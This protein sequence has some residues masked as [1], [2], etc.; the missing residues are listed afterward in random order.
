MEDQTQTL[1]IQCQEC[2]YRWNGDSFDE[3]CPYCESENI[4]VL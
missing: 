2:S 3:D 4:K 1:L